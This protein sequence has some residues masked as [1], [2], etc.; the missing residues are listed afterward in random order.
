M[1]NATLMVAA[2]EEYNY[3]RK[4]YNPGTVVVKDVA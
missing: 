4:D 3:N 2:A 1:P